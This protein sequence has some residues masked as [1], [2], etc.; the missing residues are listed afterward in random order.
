MLGLRFCPR[1][2]GVQHQ[3]IYRIDP[4][5]ESVA[6]IVARQYRPEEDALTLRPAI[7]SI[8]RLPCSP[9]QTILSAGQSTARSCHPYHAISVKAP[10]MMET[11]STKNGGPVKGYAGAAAAE[12]SQIAALTRIPNAIRKAARFGKAYPGL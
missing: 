6:K 5:C 11:V 3:R 2:R 4:N 9:P 8:A 1:I 10:A 12:N 7:E